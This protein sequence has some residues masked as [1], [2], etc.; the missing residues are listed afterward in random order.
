MIEPD[1]TIKRG[2][3][4][5][6]IAGQFLDSHDAPVDLAGS[7]SR[8]LIMREYSSP[9]TVKIDGANFVFTDASIGAWMYTLTAEDV[10]TSGLYRLEFEVT[11]PGIIDTFPTNPIRP[12][13]FVLIQDDLG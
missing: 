4:G 6:I 7:T 12:Y 11:R 2:D 10:D 1:I 5:K 3:A 9:N 13:M 8:R